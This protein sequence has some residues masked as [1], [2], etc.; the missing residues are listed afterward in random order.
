MG[1]PGQS[2]WPSQELSRY[3]LSVPGMF[4]CV[5]YREGQEIVRDQEAGLSLA[6]LASSRDILR[7]AA[8]GPC[9]AW[10]VFVSL[11]HQHHYKTQ[12]CRHWADQ[13][14]KMM[15]QLSKTLS[16]GAHQEEGSRSLSPMFEAQKGQDWVAERSMDLEI[17]HAEAWDLPASQ[18]MLMTGGLFQCSR[19]ACHPHP[20]LT[21]S[22]SSPPLEG[23]TF[24]D[25]LIPKQ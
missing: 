5:A 7:T 25:W 11:S 4:S 8:W 10:L 15:T 3:L 17:K 21:P 1:W 13:V 12:D 19:N 18:V 6:F 16:Q 22:F 9:P 24:R 23:T 2:R 20:L 14:T